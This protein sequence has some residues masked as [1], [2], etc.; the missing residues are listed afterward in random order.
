MWFGNLVTMRW[1]DDLWL[2]E[3][4]A[5]YISLPGDDR[6]H[7]LHQRM[8]GVQRRHQALGISAGPAAH[9]PPDLGRAAD[10]EIAFLNF[11]GITYGKGAS[12][13]KQLVKYIGRDTFRDG[14]RLYF[15]RHAWGNATLDDF[16]RCLEEPAAS[17]CRSGP[18]CG[19]RP[20]R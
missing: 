14:M 4:F 16:L 12:V 7:A 8:E 6:S 18:S 10:T 20:R 19:S 17:A 9:D 11:D 2:N 15:R 13:L 5:T 3:S 1:W